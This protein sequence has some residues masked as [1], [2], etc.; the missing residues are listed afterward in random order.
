LDEPEIVRTLFE[1]LQLA[2]LQRFP[3][4][5]EKL[6]APNQPGVYVLYGTKGKIRYVGLA[7]G[8]KGLRPR[9]LTHLNTHWHIA[10]YGRDFRSRGGFRCLVVQNERQRALLEAYATGCLCPAYIGNIDP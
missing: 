8:S 1:Q 10:K 4:P 5:G 9:L 7:R 2:P 6:N 3:E